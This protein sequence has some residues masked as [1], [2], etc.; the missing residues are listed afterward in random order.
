MT[1]TVRRFT[2]CLSLILSLLLS[3]C[4]P[5]G[6]QPPTLQTVRLK[7][8][9]LPLLQYAPFYI[10][11]EEGY[12]QEQAIEIEFIK[13]TRAA[14]ATSALAQGELDVQ[15]GTINVGLLN[16]IG[17]GAEIKI[18][19]DRGYV[20]PSGCDNGGFAARRALVEAGELSSPAKLKGRQI[21]FNPASFSGYVM[22]RLLNTAGL[23]L[24]DVVSVDVPDA[25]ILEA[26]QNGTIDLAYV[27]EPLLT[28]T[29]Q[30]GHAILW[31]PRR[32]I[33]PNSHNAF[34]VYGPNL[35]KK[36]P[37][38]G[39]RFMVAY[40]KAVQQYN[41]GKTERNVEIIAKHTEL[42]PEF[43]K[44]LC[45]PHLRSDGRIDTQS[46]LDFQDWAV[47]H[48]YLEKSLT[49]EQFWD[50]SFVEYANEILGVSSQ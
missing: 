27:V 44:Q 23:T 31:M 45:W 3:T 32:R 16:A 10:A 4:V 7:V 33:V 1:G 14:D 28:R 47:K 17:R 39:R 12:F 6:T 11:V 36:N 5:F 42:Q 9:V 2:S 20:A 15:G 24:D 43:L 26:L 37:D 19:A 50:P 13:L 48:G 30:A 29:L 8:V 41:Q 22:D 34:V 25:A 40:R 35:L 18:V 49:P 46:I 21:A 38:A